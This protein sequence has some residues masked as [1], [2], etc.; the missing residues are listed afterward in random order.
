MDNRDRPLRCHLDC[1]AQ[2]LVARDDRVE[3]LIERV[4]IE[5]T[6]QP[7][8]LG[9]IVERY[10]GHQLVEEP[11]SLLSRAQVV[12]QVSA[13]RRDRVRRRRRVDWRLRRCLRAGCVRIVDV[14]GIAVAMA[15]AQPRFH[16]RC[17]L[18]DRGILEEV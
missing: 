14:G 6:G 1:G 16:E 4:G 3:S 18:R 15:R 17:L 12:G 13:A 2:N 7:D 8:R 9:L 5:I 10:V 11:D